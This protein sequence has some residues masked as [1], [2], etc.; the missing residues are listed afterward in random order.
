MIVLIVGPSGVGKTTSYLTAQSQFPD[1]IFDHLDGL[2]ARW[3]MQKGII[4]RESVTLLNR[5]VNDA[6]LFLS[7]GLLAIG[8]L[9]GESPRKHIVIDMGAGFQVARTAAQL[10]RICRVITITADVKVAFNRILQAR[11]DPRT[12]DQYRQQEF[13]PTALRSTGR[14]ITRLIAHG[15]PKPRQPNS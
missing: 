2:A 6:E 13:A 4:D 3:A 10:Y 8:R 9:E 15:N 11:S 1:V 14:L 7:I 12:L 5:T